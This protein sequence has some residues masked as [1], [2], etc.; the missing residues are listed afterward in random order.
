M[1]LD[2]KNNHF[3]VKDSLEPNGK[4]CEYCTFPLTE[5]VDWERLKNKKEHQICR[6]L[7]FW[8]RTVLTKNV[9]LKS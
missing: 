4:L 6:I 2:L 8:P 5:E 9:V 1:G 3:I 7:I